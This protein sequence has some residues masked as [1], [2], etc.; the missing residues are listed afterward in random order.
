[1]VRQI[2]ST[3][4]PFAQRLA[5]VDNGTRARLALVF[6]LFLVWSLAAIWVSTTHALQPQDI[7]QA[8]PSDSPIPG[9]PETTSQKTDN[10]VAKT[11]TEYK[12]KGLNLLVLLRRGGWFMLPLGLLSV[13]VVAV[14]IER[15]LA[16]REEKM[17]PKALVKDLGQLSRQDDGF[18]P[19]L[20]YRACQVHTSAASRVIR[21]MLL[22]VGRP[23]SEID[24]AVAEASE[25]EAMRL[26]SVVSWL[27]LA[28]AVAPLIGLLGTVWGM[29]QAFYDTTQLL[30]GQN[31]AE[32]LA[33]GIYVA[34]VTTMSGL[35][36]AIPS[37]ILA[38]YYDNRIVAWFHRIDELTMS[39][40]PMFEQFEGKLRTTAS[41]DGG[42]AKA[43]A[44]TRAD[45]SELEPAEPASGSL[46]R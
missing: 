35:V 33:Q 14:G 31:K 39:L 8:T 21:A 19:R 23:Q 13:L 22:K 4:R 42:D 15:A 30:P 16:L 9:V 26:Q 34:L 45:S 24:H 17:L 7:E 28:A 25:R 38:H 29:I 36:I 27:T 32:V 10:S 3:S 37:A 12:E 20:A 6:F 1:M 5:V 2:R 18:D 11:E 41:F 46:P 43:P 44:S 40:T